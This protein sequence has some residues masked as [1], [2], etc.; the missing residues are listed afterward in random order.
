MGWS[1]LSLRWNTCADARI[2]KIRVWAEEGTCFRSFFC[3]YCGVLYLLPN[4]FVPL[5]ICFS[6]S[7][8]QPVVR[9]FELLS[10]Q[11]YIYRSRPRNR[12]WYTC[13]VCTRVLSSFSADKILLHAW[14]KLQQTR[15]SKANV[16]DCIVA[17]AVQ[18]AFSSGVILLIVLIAI[19]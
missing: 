13:E 3:G 4:V 17:T 18:R 7:L 6:E 12:K 19:L 1:V 10:N 9:L 8:N 2:M 5:P 11:S 16:V 15:S 14:P